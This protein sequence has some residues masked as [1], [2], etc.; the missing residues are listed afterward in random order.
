MWK[1]ITSYLGHVFG[2]DHRFLGARAATNGTSIYEIP[3][4]ARIS[5]AGD[6]GTGTAESEMVASQ[7]MLWDDGADLTIH[8]GDVYFVGGE[9][10]V[11]ENCL[12]GGGLANP[13]ATVRWPVGR[14]GSFAL[15]G[16]HEMYANGTA[17]FK[18]FLPALGMKSPE[19]GMPG[20]G[21]SFFCLENTY[22]RIVGIDTGYNSVGTPILG[23]IPWFKPDC[24]LEQALIRWFR[25]A[26][27]P[28]KRPKATVVLSHHQ[29][30]SAF[31]EGYPVPGKQLEEFFDGPILWLWG[32][33][34]RFAGY[35]QTR[36]GKLTTYGRCIGHGG[37]PIEP[38]EPDRN[39]EYLDR[40]W[41]Y[42]GRTN[43]RYEDDALGYNGFSK[44]QFDNQ[45]LTLRHYSL[46]LDERHNYLAKPDLMVEESFSAEG[47]S[48]IFR[49]INQSTVHEG[50]I[51]AQGSA[52]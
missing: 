48:V 47:S 24:K 8:L 49:G 51:M 18:T 11:R 7:M 32:H 16:N 44:L 6:W 27:E 46:A 15:N 42:D 33:E 2:K 30:F 21:P 20:Q 25:H 52:Q 41:F 12:G 43:P 45:N 34:H 50:I 5:I 22:W 4:N 35:K 40:L 38:G 29:Y 36:A 19:G 31:E 14:L 28:K 10:E 26:V 17:Y 3:Q 39:S 23:L 37:M 13:R 1:W 9:D